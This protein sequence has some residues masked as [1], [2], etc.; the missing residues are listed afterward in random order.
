MLG[1]KLH[2]MAIAAIASI[3]TFAIVLYLVYSE[4]RSACGT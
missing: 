1:A 3:A 4:V 2:D